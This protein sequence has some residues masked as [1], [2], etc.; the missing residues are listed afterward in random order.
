MVRKLDSVSESP[1]GFIEHRSL[2][3]PTPRVSDLEGVEWGL[4]IYDANKF[5]GDVGC[6]WSGTTC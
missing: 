5:L 2:R 3:N 6:Y 4:R 1:G